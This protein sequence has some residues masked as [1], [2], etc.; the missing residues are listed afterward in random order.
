MKVCT[1]ASGS[2]GNAVFVKSGDTSVLIDAGM[3][4]KAVRERL[5]AIGES[6]ADLSALLVT[7]EHSDHIKG[8]G[9]LCRRH[10]LPLYLT[11]KTWQDLK[12]SVGEVA[13]E[14]IKFFEA[15]DGLEIGD[16]KLDSFSI[17]HD[18]A[19]PVGYAFYEQ[20][21]KAC[22]VTDTGCMTAEIIKKVQGAD[23]MILEANHDVDM[24]QQGHYPWH[25][26]KR[27]L[28]SKGHLSNVVAGHSL[29]SLISGD[30][31]HVTLAHLSAE[32]NRPDIAYA[33]IAKILADNGLDV[34]GDLDLNVAPRYQPSKVWD[35]KAE[36][37]KE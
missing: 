33:T 24:L 6:C 23:C 1:L 14:R 25:L 17:S 4:G 31:G 21:T 27:I 13:E 7:H 16:L 26:K 12:F 36:N 15:G 8:I 11:E 2:S 29:A 18:A 20:E 28:S 34:G 19:D 35:S 32:N 37:D 30:T 5:E 10:D 22:L 9:V 3:S